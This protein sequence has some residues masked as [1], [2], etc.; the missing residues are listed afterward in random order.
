[1]TQNISLD[2][3]RKGLSQLVG[4][5]RAEELLEEAVLA[6]GYAPKPTYNRDEIRE[7]CGQLKAQGGMIG[8][9]AAAIAVR[10]LTG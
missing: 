10:L 5:E 1:M 4:V 9:V 7:I 2:E 8:V 6:K 3:L